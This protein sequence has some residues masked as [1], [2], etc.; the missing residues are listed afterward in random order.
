MQ[1]DAVFISTK[2]QATMGQHETLCPGNDDKTERCTPATPCRPG[3]LTAHGVVADPP[4]CVDERGATAQSGHCLIRAWCPLSPEH[5]GRER[6][7]GRN[8]TAATVRTST[9]DDEESDLRGI[10][11]FTLFVKS[12]V[13]FPRFGLSANNLNGTTLSPGFNLFRIE[14]LVRMAAS[15]EISLGTAA[16]S[17]A[18][19]SLSE[20]DLLEHETRRMT[21]DIMRHGTVFLFEMHWDCNLDFDP[22][23]CSPTLHVRRLD[24]LRSGFTNGF[25]F[26]AINQIFNSQSK[27]LERDVYKLS[28]L[29]ITFTNTGRGG[30]FD[31]A[32]LTLTLGASVGLMALATLAA[33]YL[34]L[35]WPWKGKVVRRS[36]HATLTKKEAYRQ[37]KFSSDERFEEVH[38]RQVGANFEAASNGKLD[39]MP[40]KTAGELRFT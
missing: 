15:E 31:A 24:S 30:K 26:R 9:A 2:V 14:E 8:A 18:A 28:G 33:D 35:Y 7:A 21:A 16:A 22:S 20:R 34:L 25:N 5:G 11:N 39:A 10:E 1:P 38:E 12:F 4:Q 13:R 17:S 27:R 23:K 29:H 32:A 6:N 19:P 37:L 36:D 3:K 40:V